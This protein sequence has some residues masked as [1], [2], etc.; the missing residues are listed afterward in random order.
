MLG[1]LSWISKCDRKRVPDQSVCHDSRNGVC[2]TDGKNTENAGNGLS[3]QCHYPHGSGRYA[4][5]YDELCHCEGMEFIF[6]VRT[7]NRY[8]CRG[9][10]RRDYDRVCI[11]Q[12]VQPDPLLLHK[13]EI[14][15]LFLIV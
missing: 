3:Y 6:R 7:K 5:L 10:G 13:E 12:N 4:V 8:D 1:F 9:N 2:G 14:K 11:F 15:E